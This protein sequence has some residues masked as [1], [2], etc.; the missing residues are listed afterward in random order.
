MPYIDKEQAIKVA[1]GALH[2]VSH[3]PAVEVAQALEDLPAADVVPKSEVEGLQVQIEHL[4]A[5]KERLNNLI[6]DLMKG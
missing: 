6:Q 5:E 2:G 3:V 1:V 4:T